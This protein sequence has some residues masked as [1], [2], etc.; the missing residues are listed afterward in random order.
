[1]G[2]ILILKSSNHWGNSFFTLYGGKSI[3]GDSDNGNQRG[4]GHSSGQ[5]N[6]HTRTFF[7]R[8]SNSYG[9]FQRKSRFHFHITSFKWTYIN[10]SLANFK[11]VASSHDK[12][13]NKQ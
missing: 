4:G 13:C 1:M 5:N 2:G 6:Y 3:W 9:H 10:C 12:L 11:R 8:K 7:S